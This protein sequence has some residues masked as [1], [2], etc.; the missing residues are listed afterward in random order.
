MP[1]DLAVRQRALELYPEHGATGTASILQAEGHQVMY[2]TIT[3]WAKR[4]GIRTNKA[5]ATPIDTSA[6]K[7]GE[8]WAVR[9][10]R[11]ADELGETAEVLSVVIRHHVEAQQLNQARNG[12]GA[13]A[14]IVD[15]CQLLSGDAT[16]R[17]ETI[18]STEALAAKARELDELAAQRRKRATG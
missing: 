5:P 16:R 2:Q 14:I 10:A 9:R 12:A 8:R 17:T 6:V 3:A 18:S 4:A 15:K 7:K 11:L 13:L 1:W